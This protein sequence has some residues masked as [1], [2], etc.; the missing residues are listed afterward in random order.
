MANKQINELTE[1]TTASGTDYLLVYDNDEAGLEKSKK[2]E[3]Y[4]A[5]G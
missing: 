3:L 5:I 1:L 2:I 4:N